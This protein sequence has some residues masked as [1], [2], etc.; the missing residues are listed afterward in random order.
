MVIVGFAAAV[1]GG[2]VYILTGGE[3]VDSIQ[4]ALIRFS[5]SSREADLARSVSSDASPVRFVVNSGDSPQLIARNLIEANLI[6]DADL[7]VDFV[8]VEGLDTE[9]EAGTYF[10]NQTQT[11]P[12][13]ARAL[14]DSSS[15]HIP[16]IILEGW[17]IEEVA[18]AV[19]SNPLFSFSGADFLVTTGRGAQVDSSFAV[20]VGLP[21]G[22][23][24]EGF[25]YPNTYQLPT[26]RLTSFATC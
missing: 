12:T 13:I 15:S 22:A 7:F 9:L 8:R 6:A 2:F 19:D 26:S 14:T 16:F 4:T 25:L 11:I 3:I 24:M 23:S 17:R 5:L 21:V 20:S 18:A 10:L 1:C